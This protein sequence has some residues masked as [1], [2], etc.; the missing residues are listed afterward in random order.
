MNVKKLTLYA[1]IL[2]FILTMVMVQDT[3]AARIKDITGFKGIRS[4]H[5]IGYGLVVGLKGSGDTSSTKFMIRSLGEALARL[6]IAG[7]GKKFK[8]KNVAAVMVTADLPPFSKQG[9]KLDVTISSIGDAK[10]L[11]GGTLLMTPLKA[12]N[13]EVYAVAQGPISI[14]GFIIEANDTTI[15]QNHPTVGRISSGALVEREVDLQLDNLEELNISLNNPDFTTATR[16]TG[17][18]ND[19]LNGNYASAVDSG[20]VKINIPSSY[21]DRIVQLISRI[22]TLDVQPDALAK[23]IL[24][25][26]TGTIV[27][28]NDVKVAPVAVAHGNLT[29]QVTTE[30]DISQPNPFSNGET[31][32]VPKT[33]ILADT[34][35]EGSLSIV[36]GL[37]IG[38]LVKALN[39][40]GVTPRDLIAIIQAIKSAGALQAQIE[41]S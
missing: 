12:A 14:G 23:V 37:S 5:L 10:S 39:E 4:N 35:E 20:S 38:E 31:T 11:Q 24:N 25:E 30:F 16:I 36:E 19:L 7:D 29:I 40:L 8:V 3:K 15:Q 9:S 22:E 17:K 18:I 1:L 2:T 32:T 41:I 6:G 34:G 28:G 21:S 33:S 13:Q 27:M 26:R